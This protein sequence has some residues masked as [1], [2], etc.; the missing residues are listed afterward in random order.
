MAKTHDTEKSP[1][2]TFGAGDEPGVGYTQAS[3]DETSTDEELLAYTIDPVEERRLLRRLDSFIAPM[4]SILYLISFRES[5]DL[6]FSLRSE[7]C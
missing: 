3:I 5:S 6:D 1:E 4:V 2:I 7:R